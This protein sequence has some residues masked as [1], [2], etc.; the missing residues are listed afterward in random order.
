MMKISK[1][2]YLC[3]DMSKWLAKLNSRYESAEFFEKLTQAAADDRTIHTAMIDEETVFVT[4][5]HLA[6]RCNSRAGRTRRAIESH[7]AELLRNPIVMAYLRQYPV[8][9]DNSTSAEKV[10]GMESTDGIVVNAVALVDEAESLIYILETGWDYCYL[11][12]IL[13]YSHVGHSVYCGNTDNGRVGLH[14][15]T[16]PVSVTGAGFVRF[17]DT[18][19]V[20]RMTQEEEKRLNAR[21]ARARS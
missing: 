15:D 13:N 18:D 21:K 3:G 14:S 19:L 2:S 17:G 20:Y 1:K 11:R 5:Y 6:E 4:G 8:C 9:L 12:T 7:I 16:V 10:I